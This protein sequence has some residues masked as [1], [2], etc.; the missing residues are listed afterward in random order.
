MSI[1]REVRFADYDVLGD[2]WDM[3]VVQREGACGGHVI[4]IAQP[5]PFA[6]LEPAQ[7]QILAQMIDIAAIEAEQL[8]RSAL[9]GSPPGDF[10]PSGK[11]RLA[12]RAAS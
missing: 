8:N 11:E 5:E 2:G 4:F 9:P 12:E 7:A 1:T 10:A 6:E 3:R